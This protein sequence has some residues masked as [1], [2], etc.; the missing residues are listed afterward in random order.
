M[1]D[2]GFDNDRPIAAFIIYK[3]LFQWRSF[4]AENTDVFDKIIQTIGIAIDVSQPSENGLIEITTILGS[5]W[6]TV[7]H[8]FASG[9]IVNS[10]SI[11]RIT[12]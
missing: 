9:Y 4:E 7:V 3:S 2:V 8:W 10:S 6:E 1:Q 11:V 12:H 5:S